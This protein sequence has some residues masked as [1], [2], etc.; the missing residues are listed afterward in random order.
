MQYDDGEIC[1]NYLQMLLGVRKVV[2]FLYYY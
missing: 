2:K 1:K